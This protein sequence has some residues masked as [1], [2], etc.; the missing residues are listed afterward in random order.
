MEA[1]HAHDLAL[2]HADEVGV[3]FVEFIDELPFAAVFMLRDF[4]HERFVIQPVNLLEFL[5]RLGDFEVIGTKLPH[6]ASSQS[7]QCRA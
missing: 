3:L 1:H 4:P 6:N 5:G 2:F 7:A